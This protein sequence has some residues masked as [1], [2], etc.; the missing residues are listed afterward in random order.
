MGHLETSTLLFPPESANLLSGS[1]LSTFHGSLSSHSCCNF[2]RSCQASE[3]LAGFPRHLPYDLTASTRAHPQSKRGSSPSARS[4]C[5]PSSASLSCT[6]G[7][8][9]LA[10]SREPE[11]GLAP[12]GAVPLAGRCE[13]RALVQAPARWLGRPGMVRSERCRVP[14]PGAASERQRSRACQRL[15]GDSGRSVLPPSRELTPRHAGRVQGAATAE[16]TGRPAVSVAG[17]SG[18]EGPAQKITRTLNEG[19]VPC[20]TFRVTRAPPPQ[21]LSPADH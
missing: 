9:P 12:S 19:P 21:P 8:L 6:S 17:S 20:G 11:T 1:A 15:E 16:D 18:R 4:S 3:R 7:R 10:V 2:D 14:E 13:K 5:S